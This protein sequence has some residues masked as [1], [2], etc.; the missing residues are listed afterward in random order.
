MEIERKREGKRGKDRRS[1]QGRRKED[2][3]CKSL[4]PAKRGKRANV[5]K[6]RAAE[7]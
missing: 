3:G 6:S 5:V 1:T 7:A 2:G 4:V